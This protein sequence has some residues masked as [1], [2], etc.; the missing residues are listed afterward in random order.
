LRVIC[1][2]IW[3]IPSR[4]RIAGYDATA[5]ALRHT[6]ER[7]LENAAIETV[8]DR[9]SLLTTDATRLSLADEAVDAATCA[10]LLLHLHAGTLCRDDAPRRRCLRELYRVLKP[11]GVLV[12][13]EVITTHAVNALAW[14]PLGYLAALLLS[15]P[16]TATYWENRVRSAGFALER[17]ER[18]LGHIV[19]IGR[20]PDATPNRE[21]SE[22]R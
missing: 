21:Q 18:R 22:R 13:V 11:G 14:T 10:Y 16:L 20:K 4:K 6:A 7:A 3:Q 2:D 1:A 12:V 8:R 5:P 15:V 19:L 9:L 17:S